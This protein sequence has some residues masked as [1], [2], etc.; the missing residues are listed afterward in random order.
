LNYYVLGSLFAMGRKK[1]ASQHDIWQDLRSLAYFGIC[2]CE[3][4]LNNFDS[5][6]AYCQKA[7][8]YDGKDPYAHYALGLSYL[9]KAVA[10]NETGDL[11]P[12]LRHLK[13]VV[14]LNPDMEEAKI[15]K[16]NIANIEKALAR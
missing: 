3:R 14:A 5:A 6:I 12:A 11:D 4:K 9:H 2:D 1:Q 15:A 10:A 13:E 16:Q 8:T 7:L